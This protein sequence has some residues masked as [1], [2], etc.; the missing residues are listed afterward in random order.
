MLLT[1]LKLK[2]YTKKQL[3]YIKDFIPD[4]LLRFI[5]NLATLTIFVIPLKQFRR[6]WYRDLLLG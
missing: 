6:D 4:F 1:D 5:S 2:Q 3:L